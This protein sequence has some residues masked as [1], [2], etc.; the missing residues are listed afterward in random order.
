MNLIH[1]RATNAERSI[2]EY[3][4]EILAEVKS[5]R[6]EHKRILMAF[7]VPPPP[8]APKRAINNNNLTSQFLHSIYTC[9][10]VMRKGKVSASY[11]SPYLL[12]GW[13][14]G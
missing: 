9:S 3:L 12:K 7:T 14:E 11:S 13:G 1:R 5:M 8:P 2:K 6:E 4:V 10:Q